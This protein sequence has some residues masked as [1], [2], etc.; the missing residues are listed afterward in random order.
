MTG[1]D[2]R[3]HAKRAVAWMLYSLREN[4]S[5]VVKHEAVREA[6][7]SFTRWSGKLPPVHHKQR[8]LRSMPSIFPWHV[9]GI[10]VNVKRSSSNDVR[11][12][13][14]K[15]AAVVHEFEQRSCPTRSRACVDVFA[16]YMHT[17]LP[18]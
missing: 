5:D 2:N 10:G 16:S 12:G 1:S 14:W 3:N 11:Y 6:S 9:A 8:V 7:K 4:A 15:R 17:A 13:T 18:P